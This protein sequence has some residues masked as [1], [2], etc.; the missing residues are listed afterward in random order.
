MLSECTDINN[1]VEQLWIKL[2]APNAKQKC[3]GCIYGPP[4][5]NIT[6][7][8]S[9][10]RSKLEHLHTFNTEII[11]TGDF[12][13]NYNLRHSDSFKQL[14]DIEHVFNL[15]QIV[16]SN[17]RVTH[18]SSTR[19]DLIFSNVEHVRNCGTIINTISDHEAVY[20]VKKKFR[21]TV[22]YD[23]KA[24]S[25]QN[26]IVKNFQHD[27][28]SDQRWNDFYGNEDVNIKW[29]IFENIINTHADQ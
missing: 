22:K 5:G 1:D 23:I 27:V 18:N 28:I 19:I 29:D 11:M 15:V 12:N 8:I 17:T 20:M 21:C 10:L 3:I 9:D 24:R 6:R 13:I 4:K 16:E 2:S 26:C 7:G 25:Y 14:K